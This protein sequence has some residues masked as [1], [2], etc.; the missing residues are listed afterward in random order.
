MLNDA[1]QNYTR[2][3]KEVLVVVFSFDKF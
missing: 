2:T 1:Q 3:K